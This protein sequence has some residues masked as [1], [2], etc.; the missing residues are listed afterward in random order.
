MVDYITSLSID[1]IFA[2]LADATR[3]DIIRR[4]I[5][6]E[7]TVSEI[8]EAYDMSL[9]AISKHLKILEKAQLISKRRQGKRQL[10]RAV[11]STVKTAEEYLQAYEQLWNRRFD[12]LEVLLKEDNR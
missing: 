11:P 10:V 3:R 4:V 6:S 1:N 7:L 2:S 9:A 8:A 5:P 12:T